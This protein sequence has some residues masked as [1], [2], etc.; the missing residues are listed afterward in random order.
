MVF[1]YLVRFHPCELL[2][3]ECTRQRIIILVEPCDLGQ[4]VKNT[5]L[6]QRRLCMQYK[7]DSSGE[8]AWMK[9]EPSVLLTVAEKS[10]QRA[11]YCGAKGS[12]WLSE[13]LPDIIRHT[14]ED[15]WSVIYRFTSGHSLTLQVQGC[16]PS[17]QPSNGSQA[18]P[19]HRR[20]LCPPYLVDGAHT[21]T[22]LRSND[23]L[24]LPTANVCDEGNMEQ[25]VKS[26]GRHE[27]WLLTMT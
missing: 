22:A 9:S 1:S 21:R 17:A 26:N 25:S 2:L 15:K 19:S 20:V 11:N 7:R 10:I 24:V 13:G 6:L 16:R 5:L 4:V 27:S 3:F 12:C 18:L 14:D 23:A 8:S